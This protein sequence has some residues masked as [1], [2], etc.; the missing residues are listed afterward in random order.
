MDNNALKLL[1]ACG[2][3]PC[4]VP[5]VA[6]FD[7]STWVGNIPPITRGGPI[8]EAFDFALAGP[9]TPW[10]W[11][12]MLVKR[13]DTEWREGR[14]LKATIQR[15]GIV[16]VTCEFEVHGPQDKN[17]TAAWNSLARRGVPRASG[18]WGI[19]EEAALT[20]TWFFALHMETEI[21][22]LK[23]SQKGGCTVLR[24]RRG[25]AP[26]GPL[27]DPVKHQVA[28]RQTYGLKIRRG[29]PQQGSA[30]AGSQKP[31][32]PAGSQPGSALAGSPQPRT[33]SSAAT[34]SAE[35]GAAA[36]AGAAAGA[37]SYAAADE[38]TSQKW[39]GG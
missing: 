30:L 25:S 6:Y 4:G 36:A 37:P 16:M 5:H 28:L 14:D 10:N 8:P 20:P 9:Y 26:R 31:L 32:E 1:R 3:N 2:E 21:A 15:E 19:G 11:Q 23:P 27:P 39:W 12:H 24:R 22:F 18:L 38:D 17:R 13:L 33:P 7:I 35:A 34:A 29:P